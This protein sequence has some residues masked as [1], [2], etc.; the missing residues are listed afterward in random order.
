MLSCRGLYSARR[1]VHPVRFHA[2]APLRHTDH[3]VRRRHMSVSEHT[4]S[5]RILAELQ[6][7]PLDE[8]KAI[9]KQLKKDAEL[10][11]D[12][13]REICRSK[14]LRL[15]ITT[16]VPMIG[17]GFVDN[18]VMILAGEFLE[19]KLGAF[20]AL[21]TLAAA[22]LG[23]LVSDVVGLGAGGFI[24]GIAM[25]IG[26]EAPPLS[27]WQLQQA[28]ARYTKLLASVIGISVGCVLGMFPLLF[29][30]QEHARLKTVFARYDIDGDGSLDRN[31]LRQAFVDAKAYISE[32]EMNYL[33]QEYD[34]DRNDKLEFDEFAALCEAV[35]KRRKAD[36]ANAARVVFAGA[37]EVII[38]E[39]SER[40][41]ERQA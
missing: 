5:D 28:V 32:A 34:V 2:A 41:K 27:A 11:D 38:A 30:D 10:E 40:R 22:G 26:L 24:E 36:P 29:Y 4:A 15:F 1:F 12:K 3:G 31:E 18:A 23:N 17:F 19:I 13:P 21:S 20:F 25:K 16:M 33:L 35:E 39:R 14:L 6:K 9:A 37:A 8:R 7:L